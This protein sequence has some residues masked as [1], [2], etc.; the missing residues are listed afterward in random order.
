MDATEQPRPDCW[1][2]S[3]ALVARSAIEGAGLVAGRPFAAGE[4]VARLGGR[5]VSDAQL[6]ELFEVA[7]ATGAYVDTVSIDDDVDLV[8][9]EGDPL[10][11]G[12][13]S[14]DPTMWWTD[15]YLLVARRDVASG[16]ELTLDYATI[17][18]DP[19]YV[20]DCRC[21]APRCRGRVTGRDWQLAALR[22][23]YGDHW[24]PGLRRRTGGGAAISE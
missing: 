15:P 12:N 9:P 5:L 16:E 7:A 11:A 6:R 23:A 3:G 18:D 24:V 14:C 8:L 22:S 4:L 10:H 2:S 20:L 19:G 1:L 17:T 21:G 13:H